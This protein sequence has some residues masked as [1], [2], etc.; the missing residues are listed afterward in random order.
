MAGGGTIDIVAPIDR[1]FA[2]KSRFLEGLSSEPQLPS[3]GPLKRLKPPANKPL[4]QSPAPE[5]VPSASKE[6]VSIA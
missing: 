3:S 6:K 4:L 2:M 1:Q 5:L